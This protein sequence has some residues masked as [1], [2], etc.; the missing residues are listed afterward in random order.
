M[1]PYQ[2]RVVTEKKELDL[3]RERLS[4]FIGGETYQTLDTTER[5]RLSEQL[6]VM[7]EYSIILG[8]RISAFPEGTR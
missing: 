6:A 5:L 3:R 7:T 4:L 2:E 1:K 8:E